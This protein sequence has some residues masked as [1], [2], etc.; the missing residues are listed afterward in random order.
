MLKPRRGA[1]TDHA[2]PLTV[3]T[4]ACTGNGQRPN[5]PVF[6]HGRLHPASASLGALARRNAMNRPVA[7]ALALAIAACFAA[8]APAA[9][10][11]DAP[12]AASANPFDQAST[13]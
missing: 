7:C 2:R 13:L 9:W 8:P 11:A 3:V 4:R 6:R 12:A 1:G 10:A 5:A